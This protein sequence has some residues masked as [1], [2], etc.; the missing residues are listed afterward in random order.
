MWSEFLIFCYSAFIVSSII[1]FISLLERRPL[2]VRSGLVMMPA[3]A[4]LSVGA[5]IQALHPDYTTLLVFYYLNTLMFV[6]VFTCFIIFVGEFTGMFNP[7]SRKSLG[8]IMAMPS[9]MVFAVVTDPWIHL[10]NSSFELAKIPDYELPFLRTDPFLVNYIWTIY[11]YVVGVYIMYILATR[12]Y[13][14]RNR[15]IFFVFLFC[16]AF[17]ALLNVGS[18]FIVDLMVIPIDGLSFT[19]GA[20]FVYT[21]ALGF[22]VFDVAPVARKQML[23]VM[24]DAIFVLDAQGMLSDVNSAGLKLIGKER[25]DILRKRPDSVEAKFPQMTKLIVGGRFDSGVEI[26]DENGRIFDSRSIPFEYGKMDQNGQML[27]MHDIT[28]RKLIEEKI[29]VAETQMKVAETDKKYRTLVDN[30]TEAII[31]YDGEGMI[32]FGNPVFEKFVERSGLAL[33][34]ANIKDLLKAEDYDIM[35]RQVRK[36]TPSAPEFHFEHAIDLIDGNEVWLHWQGKVI[37]GP[38]G[39]LKEVQAAGIN[40]TEKKR[41][42]AEYRA[43]VECQKEMIMRRT[44]DGKISFVNQAFSNYFHLHGRD[45]VGSNYFPSADD[46]DVAAFM[47]AISDLTP[48]A[49]D[50]DF[51]RLR[52][53]LE[54]TTRTT[55]WKARGIFDSKAQLIEYQCVGND[56]TERLKMEQEL[57]RT[58]K[59]ES[60]GI[61]A[62]GIAHDFNNLLSSIV[63]NIEVAT[64]E[65]AMEQS[66]RHRLDEAIRS[67]MNARHLT[68]QLLTFSKGGKPVKEP[69]DVATLL[70]TNIEFTLAGSKV[71]AEYDFADNLNYISADPFQIGQVVNNIVINA[72]QAMPEGGYIFV[73]ASNIAS[74][75]SRLG[76]PE[77]NGFVQIAIK[78]QGT[79]IPAENLNK[80][81]DPFFTTKAKGTGLGLSTVQSIVRNHH[82][83][84]DVRSEPGEGTV[85]TVSLPACEPVEMRAAEPGLDDLTVAGAR[86][87]IMDDDESILDVLSIILTE[88]GHDVK[89]ARNGEEALESVST[90]LSEGRPFD[91][92]IMDLTIRGGMGGKDAIAKIRNLDPKIRSI[93]SSGYSNDPVMA[94]PGV[95]GFDDILQKPYTIK[96]LREKLSTILKK[97]GQEHGEE[98]D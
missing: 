23:D 35:W 46:N 13:R 49:P 20:L 27:V 62:G 17:C 74:L 80:I 16:V 11:C 48:E 82:G 33:D 84:I 32:T 53:F 52:V 14:E 4:L 40:I 51:L 90:A 47:D 43:I 72:V 86:V 67:A 8:R 95:Y 81:F 38:N 91:L 10:Y 75:D 93:V 98:N 15:V 19:F 79:G 55:E 59:L 71:K 18:L 9:L 87:L 41:S 76:E 96:D 28:E 37:F 83:T 44:R 2:R 92:L 64:L 97:D 12:L 77:S 57:V 88:M 24:E 66:S 65:T 60:I 68:Q 85:F 6:V 3:C 78:D 56:I 69:V 89:I 39:S 42:E 1:I 21:A 5:M 26:V 50:H 7:Y 34:G 29:R 36:T 45:L 22:G 63:S 73:R 58:Q 30:Q 54:D 61:L 31:T 70:R 94:D 25:K